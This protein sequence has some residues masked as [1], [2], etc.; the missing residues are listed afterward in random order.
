MRDKDG[1]LNFLDMS[2]FIIRS[3]DQTDN[4]EI[5]KVIRT[6]MTSFGAIGEGFSIEDP[7]VDQMYEA[8][9]ESQSAM[10][11]VV[12]KEGNVLGCGGFA[13]LIGGDADTCELRKMYFLPEARGKGLGRKMLEMALIGAKEKGFKKC[14]LETLEHMTAARKLY[15]KAGFLPLTCSMGNTGHSG[16]DSFYL[17]EL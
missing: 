7:E 9:Q 5:A 17:I 13:P 4:V 14:Y 16:C 1:F 8:Y 10:Y 6:V 12:G 3:I 15:E 11:V 2:D